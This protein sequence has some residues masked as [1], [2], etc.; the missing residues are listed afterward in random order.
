MSI[1]PR[2]DDAVEADDAKAAENRDGANAADALVDHAKCHHVAAL[3]EASQRQ[4]CAAIAR[5]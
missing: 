5:T 3:E 2:D 1:A 4:L